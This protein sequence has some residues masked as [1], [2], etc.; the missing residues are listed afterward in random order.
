MKI[1]E[2]VCI[3][4]IAVLYS[5]HSIV[6]DSL[7]VLFVDRYW[8][9]LEDRNVYI[10][11]G[12]QYCVPSITEQYSALLSIKQCLKSRPGLVGLAGKV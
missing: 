8:C 10:F 12:I 3:E 9:C 1:G 2:A 7:C 11:T 5:V 4:H 6:A